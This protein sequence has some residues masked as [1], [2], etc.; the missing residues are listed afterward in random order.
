MQKPWRS[1]N[2]TKEMS[3]AFRWL[4]LWLVHGDLL[5][6][7]SSFDVI[8][9]LLFLLN[10]VCN[11]KN[12]F[13]LFIEKIFCWNYKRRSL[14]H[15]K[16][17]CFIRLFL[18][19]AMTKMMQGL[20]IVRWIF[21][22]MMMKTRWRWKRI[23]LTWRFPGRVDIS[24]QWKMESCVCTRILTLSIRVSR[25]GRFQ[26]DWNFSLTK[27]SCSLSLQMDLCKNSL[28]ISHWHHAS[29]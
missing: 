14:F 26:I 9:L 20:V 24:W 7:M 2:I 21:W 15:Q 3:A 23:L 27:A 12:I 8:I 13:V 18:I 1:Q 28:L 4:W 10:I 25:S 29:L 16:Q 17:I 19:C 5:L 6:L 11:S 22:Q